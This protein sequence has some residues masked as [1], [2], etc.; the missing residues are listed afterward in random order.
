MPAQTG[1]DF[2]V[3]EDARK[4]KK[5]EAKLTNGVPSSKTTRVDESHALVAPETRDEEDLIEL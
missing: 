3:S 4:G 2:L 1:F 5:L